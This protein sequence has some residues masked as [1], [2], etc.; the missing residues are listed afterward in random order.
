MEIFNIFIKFLKY[1]ITLAMGINNLF[2]KYF[3]TGAILFIFTFIIS[4]V[5][6]FILYLIG[7]IIFG[8]INKIINTIIKAWR[9]KNV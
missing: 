3:V 9:N 7:Q 6:V 4:V 8:I 2:I 1:L 5:I